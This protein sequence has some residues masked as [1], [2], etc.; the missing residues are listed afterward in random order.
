MIQSAGWPATGVLH[1]RRA[2]RI[3][4]VDD[5]EAIRSGLQ[6]LLRSFAMDVR[7]FASA[8]VF[9]SS[10]DE[11]ETDCLITDFQMPGMNGVQLRQELLRRGHDFPVIVITAY[12]EETARKTAVA[13]GVRDFLEKPIDANV[14]VERIQACLAQD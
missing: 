4:V 12:P 5:D 13:L 9:L 8:E 6:S 3:S 10:L 11:T 2:S 1:L 7:T 14:L